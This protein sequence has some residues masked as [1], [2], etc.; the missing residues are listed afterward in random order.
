MDK[1]FFD[2]IYNDEF[3]PKKTVKSGKKINKLAIEKI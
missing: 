2:V 3:N 1:L